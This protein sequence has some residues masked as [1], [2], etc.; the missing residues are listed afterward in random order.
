MSDMRRHTASDAMPNVVGDPSSI[1]GLRPGVHTSRQGDGSRD[2]DG[3]ELHF[4]D[5]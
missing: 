1:G 5:V 4:G 3:S 2:D